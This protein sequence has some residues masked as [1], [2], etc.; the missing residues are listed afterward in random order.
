MKF[1]IKSK[2]A[3]HA[4]RVTLARETYEQ[5]LTQTTLLL[6]QIRA[7]SPPCEVFEWS[8]EADCYIRFTGQP[9]LE[10]AL[11]T[12]GQYDRLA[13]QEVTSVIRLPGVIFLNESFA[14]SVALINE[15]KQDLHQQI[16]SVPPGSRNRLTTPAFGSQTSTLQLYRK[17]NEA[18]IDTIKVS[19]TEAKAGSAITWISVAKLRQRLVDSLDHPSEGT[20]HHRWN[21]MLEIELESLND[22]HESEE[23]MIQKPVARHPRLLIY[24]VQGSRHDKMK[25]ASV[26]LICYAP[27]NNVRIKPF[28]NTQGYTIHR[29]DTHLKT[30]IIERLH[31]FYVEG[32]RKRTSAEESDV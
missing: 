25:G 9:A 2:H 18:Q 7:A 5:L 30:L 26:P 8:Q 19:F 12:L 32:G 28:T 14:E 4:E 6:S 22:F 10:K 31:V 3:M 24:K 23:L 20:D 13:N 1:D 11:R 27:F 21:K 16:T 29:S 15:L 17:W